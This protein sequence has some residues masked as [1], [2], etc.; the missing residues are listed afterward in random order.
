MPHKIYYETV[1]ENIHIISLFFKISLKKKK[2]EE[3]EKKRKKGKKKEKKKT[4]VINGESEMKCRN[5][6]V[7]WDAK[8]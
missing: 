6:G 5:D 3:K 4:G 8:H 1:V 2:R 7:W